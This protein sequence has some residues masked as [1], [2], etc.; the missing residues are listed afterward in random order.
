MPEE[1]PDA[2]PRFRQGVSE[3]F[4]DS[5]R[6][7][8]RRRRSL[9]TAGAK[10]VSPRLFRR[11]ARKLGISFRQE[12]SPTAK[13]YPL[14]TMGSGVALFDDD[15]DGRLGFFFANGARLDDPT[16]KGAIP[17]E[18][19]PKYWNRLYHQKPNGTFHIRRCYG[20]SGSGRIRVFHRRSG[21][22]YDDDGFEDLYVAGYLCWSRRSS[23]TTPCARL[24]TILA[25]RLRAGDANRNRTSNWRPQPGW[26]MSRPN[27]AGKG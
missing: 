18:D 3:R 17:R 22:D 7:C 12:A 9:R 19:G 15:N 20:K 14:E 23:V 26:S 5:R 4:H 13:K 27:I 16:A 10:F 21:R 6:F 2:L 8:A 1:V 24:T 25:S 11:C